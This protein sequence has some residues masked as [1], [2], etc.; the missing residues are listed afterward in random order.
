MRPQPRYVP[1]SRVLEPG[2]Y[3]SLLATSTSLNR[4]HI[5]HRRGYPLM[6]I[7]ALSVC[8]SV[9]FSAAAAHAA[10]ISVGAGGDLQGAI[11]AARPGD[12]IV[13]AAGATFTGNYTLPAKGGGSFITIRSSG[14]LSTIVIRPCPT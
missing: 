6:K 2:S 3:G 4:I 9:L 14:R 13:I 8:L 5:V 12:T 10:T 11:N 7:R 1:K